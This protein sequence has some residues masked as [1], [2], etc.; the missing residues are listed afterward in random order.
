MCAGRHF[1]AAAEGRKVMLCRWKSFSIQK[2]AADS[3]DNPTERRKKV[4]FPLSNV[5]LFNFFKYSPACEIN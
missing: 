2:A 1:R 3:G 5:P 4:N